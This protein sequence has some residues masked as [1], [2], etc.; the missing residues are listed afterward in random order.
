M[1]GKAILFT[2]NPIFKEL[3]LYRT[4]KTFLNGEMIRNLKLRKTQKE[5]KGKMIKNLKKRKT[6]KRKIQHVI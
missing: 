5:K 2:I 3:H 4:F 1:K 6:W